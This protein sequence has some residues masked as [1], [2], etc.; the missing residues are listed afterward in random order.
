[1]RKGS[2][3][4][5]STYRLPLASAR[6]KKLVCEQLLCSC[7]QISLLSVNYAFLSPAVINTALRGGVGTA[8][9]AE[10]SA[11]LLNWCILTC[12]RV[13]SLGLIN[14]KQKHWPSL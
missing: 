4:L 5:G 14:L 12:L 1:M 10:V 11:S 2:C 13:C 3:Q 8:A 7:N 6:S 9:L